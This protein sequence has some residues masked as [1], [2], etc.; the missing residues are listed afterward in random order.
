ML[1]PVPLAPPPLVLRAFSATPGCCPV[2]LW[3]LV[4][5]R[6]SSAAPTVVVRLLSRAKPPGAG[7]LCGA[8]PWAAASGLLADLEGEEGG[9]AAA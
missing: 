8:G 2:K 6:R 9:E 1:V 5:M 4:L 7:A 3:S